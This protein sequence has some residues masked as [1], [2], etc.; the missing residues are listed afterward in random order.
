MERLVLVAWDYAAIIIYAVL[1]ILMAAFV[2]EILI[3]LSSLYFLHK[4]SHFF[5]FLKNQLH[6]LLN[7]NFFSLGAGML[8]CYI[9]IHY[10]VCVFGLLS[11]RPEIIFMH[12][13]S[14]TEMEHAE[15][16]KMRFKFPRQPL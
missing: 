5:S 14:H 12:D 9:F 4:S 15:N 6:L 7:K 16:L 1:T 13:T 2:S 3:S 8:F 10:F 11:M